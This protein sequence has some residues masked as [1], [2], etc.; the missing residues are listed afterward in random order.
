MFNQDIK[1]RYL[2]TLS[3]ATSA[4]MRILFATAEKFEVTKNLD[5]ACFDSD[6]LGRL[7][8]SFGFSEPETVRSRKALF[9]SYADWYCQEQ[10]GETH[11]LREYDVFSF[12]YKETFASTLILEPDD[13]I[14]K[15]TQVYPLD[16]AQPVIPALCFAW[17]G[18]DSAI[19]L[20]L[21]ASKVDTKQGKIYVSDDPQNAMIMPTCFREALDIY[22]RTDKAD[23]VQG[24]IFTVYAHTNGQFIKKMLSKQSKKGGEPY[25]T[26]SMSSL[27]TDL[28]SRYRE[29]DPNDE[30]FS[31]T[32]VMRSGHFYRLHQLAKSGVDV[33]NIRNKELVRGMLGKGKRNHKDNMVLYDVYREIRASAGLD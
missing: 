29:I 20:S 7:L 24:Q 22:A 6:D 26:K 4:S 12:P 31:Y 9:V 18:I 14:R 25:T 8:G 2:E 13:L 11:S 15:I 28:R 23:R 3:P 1:E 19:A 27:L 5:V 32:N 16:S 17:M 30:S 10:Y 33:H 21:E